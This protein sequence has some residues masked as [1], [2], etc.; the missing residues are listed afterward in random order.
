MKSTVNFSAFCDS[1]S[2][3]YKNN[4]SYEGKRALFDYLTN[5][6]EETGEEMELDPVAFCCD[7]T[8]YDSLEDLN[9]NYDKHY[10][11]DTLRDE[12]TVIECDNGHIIIQAF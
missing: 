10:T 7:F 4:F 9:G 8:E 1:F 12:T 11:L 3:T 5:Y 6:E 2:E